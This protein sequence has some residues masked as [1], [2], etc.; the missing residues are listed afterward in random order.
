MYEQPQQPYQDSTPGAQAYGPPP[1]GAQMKRR[2]VFAVWLGLPL[3][4]LGI[5]SLVWYYKIHE[6]MKRFDP[7]AKVDPA[8]SLLTVMFGWVACGI[9]PLVSYYN[10]GTRIANAQR[11]AGLPQ[12]C[13]PALGLILNVFFGVGALYYQSELNK[14]VA[15]YGDVPPGSPVQLA[16]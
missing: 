16:I 9:P 13:A 5:Y 7:R 10:T 12:T 1:V 14:V 2:N 4:T 15:H 11:A 3:I 8:G 6:E